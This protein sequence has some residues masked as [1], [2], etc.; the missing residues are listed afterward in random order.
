MDLWDAETQAQALVGLQTYRRT[1]SA[2]RYEVSFV[3]FDLSSRWLVI[4]DVA[5]IPWEDLLDECFEYAKNTIEHR[6]VRRADG[7]PLTKRKVAALRRKFLEGLSNRRR[8]PADAFESDGSEL[9]CTC[10]S[11]PPHSTPPRPDSCPTRGT[12]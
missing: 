8:P 1:E 2:G 9:A 10:R 11:S 6:E 3:D 4:D 7:K 5:D 12:G